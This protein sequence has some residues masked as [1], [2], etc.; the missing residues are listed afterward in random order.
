MNELASVEK[1]KKGFPKQ[2]SQKEKQTALVEHR[3]GESLFR[4]ES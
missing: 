4:P 2:S 1:P 3:A